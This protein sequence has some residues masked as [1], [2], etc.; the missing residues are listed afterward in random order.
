MATHSYMFLGCQ[1][2]KLRGVA[3]DTGNQLVNGVFH[4]LG[5]VECEEKC[6]DHYG[7]GCKSLKFCPNIDNV[8]NP[9]GDGTCTLFDK[10]LGVDVVLNN[11]PMCHS[12]YRVDCQEGTF[13]YINIQE[14]LRPNF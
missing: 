11:D 6:D 4:G 5:I 9:E 8:N 13:L 10:Q 1:Y 14:H 7:M 3:Q 2:N 12:S